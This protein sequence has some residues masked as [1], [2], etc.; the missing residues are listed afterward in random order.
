MLDLDSPG[1]EI[2]GLP[3]AADAIRAVAGAKP[4]I[5]VVNDMACSAAYVLAAAATEV[6]ASRTSIVGSV[7]VV[8][9]HEDLSGLLAQRGI[10]VEWVFAGEKKVDGANTHPLS[11]RAR[12]DMQA[13]V[14][15]AYRLIT[16]HVARSRGMDVGA[17]RA[18]EAGT[19]EG[20]AAIEVGFVDSIG[21]LE[22]AT[23]RARSL[24]KPKTPQQTGSRA[25]FGHRQSFRRSA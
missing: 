20:P 15:S 21:T 3:D 24:A 19:F 9:G 10:R 11:A 8:W 16:E 18:T 1:G 13:E 5:A 14:D 6:I 7:G 22:D 25:R 4:V 2:S 12:A 23:A 17:V